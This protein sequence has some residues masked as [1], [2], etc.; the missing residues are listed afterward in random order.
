[1][2]MENINKINLNEIAPNLSKVSQENPFKVPDGYFA[3]LEQSILNQTKQISPKKPSK[4]FFSQPYFY[5]PAAAIIILA[6][7]LSIINFS[8]I[9][10][11]K[12]IT[13][14]EVENSFTII[15]EKF[16]NSNL[17]K[18]TLDRVIKDVEY[19]DLTKENK[20][21]EINC[22]E[23]I[24][25]L[26]KHLPEYVEIYNK[27]NKIV[28]EEK[29]QTRNTT[30]YAENTNIE[31]TLTIDT[32]DVETSTY[33]D[34]FAGPFKGS[35]K[36]W[37]PSNTEPEDKTNRNS[38]L[39]VLNIGSDTCV[40]HPIELNAGNYGSNYYYEWSTGERTQ[41]INVKRSGTYSLTVTNKSNQGIKLVD[42][43]RVNIV[44]TPNFSLDPMITGCE[45]QGVKLNAYAGKEYSYYWYPS[46]Q[47]TPEITVRKSG[48]YIV[49]VRACET[50]RDTTFVTI[51]KCDL[52]IPASVSPNNDGKEDVFYI[53]N[54]N[55]YKN[56]ALEI[57][58]AKGNQVFT[59]E[60]YQNDWNG[61]NEN[62]GVYY[63]F[64]KFDD[65]TSQQG[66]FTLIK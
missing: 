2:G 8:G 37:T 34:Q 57:F 50:Y 39:P 20:F 45:D 23:R 48:M 27:Y 33:Q 5:L 6:L 30:Y 9:D 51:K 46:G 13:D 58:D 14:K 63:Y 1:M 29:I 28:I 16:R 60:N 26:E 52:K 36:K 3:D 42:N 54:L 11:K 31:E 21:S 7:I 12:S 49:E 65:K 38:R 4:P 43:I 18:Q 66:T 62:Q 25:Q 35:D 22:I 59:S 41:T 44:P 47:L 15:K 53:K 40:H 19:I 17:K 61:K 64:L 10:N 24:S 32:E 55:N 56:T